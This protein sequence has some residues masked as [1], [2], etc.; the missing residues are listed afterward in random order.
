MNMEIYTEWLKRQGYQVIRTK[1]S[2]W[3][4][5]GPR[6][7]QAIPNGWIIQPSETELRN[8]LISQRG[9]ALRY[10]TPLDSPE[11]LVSYH[12][13]LYPLYNLDLISTKARNGVRHGLKNTNVEP[14][15]FKRLAEE[16][17]NLQRSTLERQG[18]LSSMT[19]AEW[20]KLC[21]AAENLPGLVAWGGIVAGELAASIV[22]VRIDDTYYVPYAQSLYNF[23][24][25]HVNNAVFYVA[26]C[27]ML[28]Q[29]GI[30]KIFWSL[31]SLDAPDSINE[32]K[33]RMNFHATP[34][35]QRVVLHPF[36]APFVNKISYQVLK[37]LSQRFPENP[38]LSKS[39]GMVRFNIEGKNPIFEQEWPKC[40]SEY[41]ENFLITRSLKLV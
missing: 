8:L 3:Y 4:N 6:V 36:L 10:S 39:E 33:F 41:R 5:A 9:L 22:T 16:G 30:K 35:R 18:R 37:W 7:F 14:I 17:W 11:G 12:V 40:I 2:Y 34:V 27:D 19:Q 24:G 15:S 26:T 1:S 38:F 29:P 21:L 32:F 20:I 25:M 28:N 23:L 31:H 13:D